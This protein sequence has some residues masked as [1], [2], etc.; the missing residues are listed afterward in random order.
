MVDVVNS[1]N[2]PLGDNGQ[3]TRFDTCF[4]KKSRVTG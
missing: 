2:Q 4:Y 1:R 3:W